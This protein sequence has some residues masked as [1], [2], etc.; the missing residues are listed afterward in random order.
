[1]DTVNTMI[2]PRPTRLYHLTHIDHLPTIA[3]KGLFAD[4]FAA[5]EGLLTTEIGQRSIKSQRRRR[6]VPCGAEGVVADY[7]PFYFAPRSPM[8]SAIFYNRVPEYTGGQEPLIYLVST[9]E[10]MT[11]LGLELVFTDRNAALSITRFT[12]DVDELDVLVDWPLISAKM[13][14]NT[15]EEPDR[16][17]RRMAECLVHRRVP[18]EAFDEI[19]TMNDSRRDQADEIVASLNLAIPVRSHR[20]C[21]F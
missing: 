12:S 16:R 9:V 4:T 19:L 18:W 11:D 2:R 1:M 20:A 10:K 15:S 14:T 5:T 13:W 6:Q 17:E 8:L 21:Y 7:A 3:T